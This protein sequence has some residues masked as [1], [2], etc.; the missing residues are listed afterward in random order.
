MAGVSRRRGDYG[1]TLLE[2]LVALATIAVLVGGTASI[3]AAAGRSLARSRLDTTAVMLAHGRL[4]QLNA[5]SW[6]FGSAHA[7]RPGVDLE[8]D[9]SGRD[10]MPGGTGLGTAPSDALD[11]DTPG[12]VDHLDASGRWIAAGTTVPSGA[13]FTR[14]WTVQHVEGFPDI[15]TLRVRVVDRHA[16]VRDVQLSSLRV[17]TAG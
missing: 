7:P 8:T 14:R 2:L 17:R 5:L 13:R 6:G 1:F 9:L 11:V 4:E 16:E 15:V 12:F 10:P 3:M